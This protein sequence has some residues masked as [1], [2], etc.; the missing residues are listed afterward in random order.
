MLLN[1]VIVIIGVISCIVMCCVHVHVCECVEGQ[2]QWCCWVCVM[3]ISMIIIIIVDVT[4]ISF[5][6][7][8]ASLERLPMLDKLPLPLMMLLK[9]TKQ[10]E[11]YVAIPLCA[12]PKR[13]HELNWKFLVQCK[14]AWLQIGNSSS[15]SARSD[16]IYIWILKLPVD[17]MALI[18]VSAL[19]WRIINCSSPNL[20]SRVTR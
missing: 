14:A 12:G 7:H 9:L 20:A 11:I 19:S 10:W 16:N 17:V 4:P 13:L 1:V 2:K 6:Q 8:L 18:L 3:I 15:R 5:A